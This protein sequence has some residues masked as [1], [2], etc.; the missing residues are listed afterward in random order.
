MCMCQGAAVDWW[1]LGVCLYE[2]LIGFPPFTDDTPELVFNNILSRSKQSLQ[3]LCL[4][5]VFTRAML[6]S[7]AISCRLVSVRLSQVGCSTERA[8]RGIIQTMPHDI[9]ET[10]GFWCRKSLQNS[11]GVMRPTTAT[12]KSH[13]VDVYVII[14]IIISSSY[15]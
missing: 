5:S 15:T 6:A 3:R 1:A 13:E 11:N 2:F 10:L 4:L 14:I 9:P 12:N 7:A 8:K